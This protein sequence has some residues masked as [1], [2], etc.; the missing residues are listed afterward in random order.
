MNKFKRKLL[1]WLQHSCV[2][3]DRMVAVDIL[4]GCGDGTEVAYC[5]N[6]GAVKVKM[7][8]SLGGDWR[9]PDPFLW[10]SWKWL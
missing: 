8:T 6:C 9:L 7:N 1:A 3:P 5:R 4:E 10:E 2:H